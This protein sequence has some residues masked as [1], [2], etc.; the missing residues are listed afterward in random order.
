LREVAAVQNLSWW[1]TFRLLEVPAAMIGLVWNSMMSMAGGWFFLMV[2]EAFRLGDHDYRLPGIGSYASEAMNQFDPHVA[3]TW[4]PVIAAIIMMTLMILAVDQLFWRPIVV[5]SQRFKLEDQAVADPPQSW[6][7]NI[8]SKSKIYLGIDR[9]LRNRRQRKAERVARLAASNPASDSPGSAKPDRAPSFKLE[10]LRAM[11]QRLTWGVLIL[12]AIWGAVVMIRLLIQLPL[13]YD[14]TTHADWISVVLALLASFLRTTAAVAIGAAWAL[15]VGIMIGRS[16]TWSRR[17]QPVIQVVASFPAPML[18]P[19][20]IL[21]LAA[22]HMPFT[23]GCV[24]LM[25]LGAQ[26]YIL[27][28]VI[29]SASAI[30]HDLDEVASVYRMSRAER[31]KRL[32]LPCVFPYLVTGL[33]TAAGGAWNATI[34]AE[35]VTF[36]GGTLTAFGLGSI[37]ND[38]TNNANFP[39]LAAGVVTMAVFVVLLNRFFWKRLYR[40]AEDRYSLNV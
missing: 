14:G 33:I 13:R 26:W 4:H 15:P 24:A 39:L 3:S 21:I 7:L 28:N 30:P 22:I 37:I 29:A 11:R 32:Y 2:N 12:V 27:F 34:V 31:W 8:L 9:H 18:F 1:Q 20:V 38:A 6:V 10:K 19:L 5:W 35:F 40:L 23:I 36:R 16:R 25:L 17:L